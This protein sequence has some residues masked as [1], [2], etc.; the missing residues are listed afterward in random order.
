MWRPITQT[1]A[2]RKTRES[3]LFLSLD[4]DVGVKLRT[5]LAARQDDDDIAMLNRVHVL[6]RR[7]RDHS[8][9]VTG[10]AATP[11]LACQALISSQP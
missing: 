1:K 4:V 7:E 9:R 5:I 2:M 11:R 10:M 6:R 8:T 3:F